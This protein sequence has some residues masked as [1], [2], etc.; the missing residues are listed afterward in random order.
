M[1]KVYV[2]IQNATYTVVDYLENTGH[3]QYIDT[4][5]VPDYDSGFK[6]EVEFT[7]TSLGQIYCLVSNYATNTRTHVSCEINALN[8]SRLYLNNGALS[9]VCNGVVSG[10]N[11]S[12]FE[13]SNDIL[14]VKTNENTEIVE[15]HLGLTGATTGSAY[16]YVDR[17]KRFSTFAYNLRIH[18]CKIYN[19]ATLVRDLV[20]V[21]RNFDGE[22]G[23][24][25]SVNDY[26][27][28]NQ[29]TGTF[30]AGNPTGATIQTYTPVEYLEGTGTQYIDTGTR[31]YKTKTELTFQFVKPLVAQSVLCG[32]YSSNN[33]YYVCQVS[34]DLKIISTDKNAT[35]IILQNAQDTNIH[36]LVY[37]DSNHKVIFD[38]VEKGTVSDLSLRIANNLYLFA[39][40][41]S[42]SAE[43]ICPARIYACKIWDNGTLVRDFVPVLDTNNVACLYDKVTQTYFRN[44]GTGV[45]KAGKPIATARQGK[46]IYIGVPIQTYTPIE[47]LESTGTQYINM[48]INAFGKSTVKME[49]EVQFSTSNH[50]Q[51]MGV[52]PNPYWGVDINGYYEMYNASSTKASSVSFDKIT[53]QM[54]ANVKKELYVNNEKILEV[55]TPDK[56]FVSSSMWLFALG[57]A[58]AMSVYSCN[59]K[60][61][62]FKL[63]IDDELV[64][65]LIPVKDAN[66]VGY[67]YDK[68]SGTAYANAGTGSFTLGNPTGEVLGVARKCVKAYIGAPNTAYTPLEYI[69]STGTQYIDTGINADSKVKLDMDIQLN[70]T[71]DYTNTFGAIY[72]ASENNYIREHIHP[73]NATQVVIA[74]TGTNNKLFDGISASSRFHS[75]IDISGTKKAI[76]TVNDTTITTTLSYSGAGFGTAMNFWLFRRNSN[77]STLRYYTKMKLYRFKMY[78]DGELVRDYIPAKRNS[79]DEIGLYENVSGTF[80]TNQ[81]T[82]TFTAGDPS[83]MVLGVAHEFFVDSAIT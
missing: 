59:V 78:Y 25:D 66:G 70:T 80:Y 2:G 65:D 18:S 49:T 82:G 63:Y 44:S 48:N 17:S 7:P 19:G 62:Y 34:S 29:G 22:L 81:G 73:N 67:M 55:S 68:I 43:G 71:F 60:M 45:F 6:I 46:K 1:K 76:T 27:Y 15:S 5:F 10:K 26:F 23:F 83:G 32:V 24:Y 4:G 54:T 72:K 56:T 35:V 21:R 14:T 75:V 57:N 50:R 53:Y 58:G 9:V 39:R 31:P 30:T 51:L 79:D 12:T 28:T 74:L 3:T 37:N 69:E 36:T 13:Y 61:K 42:S 52:N 11:K 77:D 47:Y 8:Y 20:P 38:N 33:R 40:R 16:L 41:G 64:R